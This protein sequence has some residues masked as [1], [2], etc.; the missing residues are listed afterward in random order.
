MSTTATP[1]TTVQLRQQIARLPRTPLGHL[2]TPLEPLPRFS[3]ALGGPTVWIKRDDCTG[4]AFGGNKTR[5][6]EFILAHA[7]Q[8]GAEKLLW[9]AGVQSNNCRQTAAACAKLG[10]ACHLMLGRG[11][12]SDE[13]QGNL[14]LD[15]LLGAT[16]EMVDLPLG[17]ELYERIARRAEQWR[18][19]G[20]RVY[21][22]DNAIVKPRAAVSY[23]LCLAEIV[24]QSARAGEKPSAVYVASAG[25]TAAG[26]LLGKAA[27]AAEIALRIVAPIRWPWDHAADLAATANQAAELIGLPAMVQPGDVQTTDQ[28]L[29]DGYGIPSAAGQEALDLLARTEGILVEPVYT[30][31]A[32]AALIDDVRQG[33]LSSDRPVVFLH[34]GGTPALFAYRDELLRRGGRGM[35][36]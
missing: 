18:A 25:S 19:E 27:L 21:C 10:L 22:W 6:N 36:H 11:G 33:R 15:Y 28:Y 20:Q 13:I 35:M 5:H 1:L 2:P 9:G 32:L 24:E 26:L 17:P 12:H 30:A 29:G 34:T 4:L 8:L 23:A 16:V 14:L 31:K 3:A 7:L